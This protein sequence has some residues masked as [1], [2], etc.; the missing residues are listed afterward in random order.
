MSCDDACLLSYLEH[1][2][3][4][5]A[6]GH[7]LVELRALGEIRLAV[8][9]LELKDIGPALTGGSDHLGAVDL[10]KVLA[11]EELPEQSADS[12]LDAEDG[13]IGLSLQKPTEVY[14][15]E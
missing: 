4:V 11:Q 8:K 10:H 6:D 9:V 14:R 13:L 3:H 7:L 2:L 5:C 12:T 15:R 1:S